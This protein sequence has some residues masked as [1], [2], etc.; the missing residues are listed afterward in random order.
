[1]KDGFLQGEGRK[2]KCSGF[3]MIKSV[4]QFAFG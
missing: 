3:E 2:K 1:M 4:D